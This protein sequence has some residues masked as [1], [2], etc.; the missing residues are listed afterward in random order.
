MLSRFG[1]RSTLRAA[2]LLAFGLLACT[3]AEA[4]RIRIPDSQFP[5]GPTLPTVTPTQ[6]STLPPIQSPVVQGTNPAVVSPPLMQLPPINSAPGATLGPGFDAYAAPGTVFPT[7]PFPQGTTGNG[8]MIYPPANAYPWVGPDAGITA[9]PPPSFAPANNSPSIYGPA[10]GDATWQSG[11]GAWPNS[12]E[13]WPNQAW[14]RVSDEWLPRLVEHPRLRHTYLYGEDG[15][16]LGINDAE[17]ATTLTFPGF[18]CLRQPWRVSPGFIFHF[19]DG[20][21][22]AVTGVDLP[23][24]A[25][26]AYLAFDYLTAA[27]RPLGAEINFTVGMYTDFAHVTTDSMRLTG[28][29]VGWL[30]LDNTTI[31]K[32]GVEYLD[33]LDIKLLPAFGV[34]MMPNSDLKIDLYFPRPKIARRIPNSYNFEI[35]GYLG[36][37]YGGGSWTIEREGGMGDQVDINDIRIFVGGEWM[38]RR[39]VTGFLEIGYVFNRELVYKSL[40]DPVDISDTFMIRSGLA[41]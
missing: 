16:D 22:T 20:P 34:F 8:A 10:F 19:W 6:F 29:G 17:L 4:Q 1:S 33:R 24:K 13:T 21:D 40:L 7:A 9:S 32:L 14:S 18:C 41:F 28:V 35:W 23:S 12:A 5:V 27:N 38:G 15:N 2:T 3:S 25:Y 39:Q 26:S 37:E 36:G 11:N 31:A 30:R